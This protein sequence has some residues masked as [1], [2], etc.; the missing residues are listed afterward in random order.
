MHTLKVTGRGAEHPRQLIYAGNA[1]GAKGGA[2]V[3]A[4]AGRHG[5]RGKMGVEA[6][7]REAALEPSTGKQPRSQA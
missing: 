4:E 1:K 7:H 6:R 3:T 2:R 5:V